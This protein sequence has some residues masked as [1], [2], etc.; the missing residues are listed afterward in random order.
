MTSST[1][2]IFETLVTPEVEFVVAPAGYNL[3]AK[4]SPVA[5][6]AVIISGVVLS[7]KYKVINGSK[8]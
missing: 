4:T 1:A 5:L 2:K 7:V 3:Q 8:G 6:A